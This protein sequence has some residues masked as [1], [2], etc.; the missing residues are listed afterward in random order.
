M[1]KISKINA[2]KTVVRYM[3]ADNYN[4]AN[5]VMKIIDRSISHDR[6]NSMLSDYIKLNQKEKKYFEKK[7]L[8]FEDGQ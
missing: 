5:A 1:C 4:S 8:I 6:K 2:F 7:L 3:D